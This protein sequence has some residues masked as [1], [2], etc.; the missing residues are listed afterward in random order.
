MDKN[1]LTYGADMLFDLHFLRIYFPI[2][3]GARV[4]YLPET[5][6]WKPELLFTIDVN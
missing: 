1:Y 4:A 6:E 2:S 5:S 3:I